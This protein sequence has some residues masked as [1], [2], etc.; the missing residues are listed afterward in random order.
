M[1]VFRGRVDRKEGKSKQGREEGKNG[2]KVFVN[3]E[4]KRGVGSKGQLGK[5]NQVISYTGTKSL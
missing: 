5:K 2:N 4:R 3:G 1:F